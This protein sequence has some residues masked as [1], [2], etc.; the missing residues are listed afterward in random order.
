MVKM[1]YRGCSYF[2]TGEAG[3]TTVWRYAFMNHAPSQ[4]FALQRLGLDCD[5]LRI[6]VKTWANENNI[7]LK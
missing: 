2:L 7:L 1:S 5:V 6:A 3:T 4:E